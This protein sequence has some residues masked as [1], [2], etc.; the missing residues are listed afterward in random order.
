L[1]AQLRAQQE[2]LAKD[3]REAAKARAAP[4]AADDEERRRLRTK[5]DELKGQIAE[6]NRERGELRKELAQKSEATTATAAD[7]EE[8][9]EPDIEGI[10]ADVRV[11]GVAIPRFAKNASEAFRDAPARIARDALLIV[12]ELAAGDAAAWGEVKQLEKARTPVFSARVGIHYRMLFRTDA[13]GMEVL[14]LFH[15]KNLEST[16]KRYA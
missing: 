7:E 6:G 9:E 1:E 4:T 14:E 13:A 11:R 12:A 5:I 8:E 10:P 15:R 3:E 2:A 16:V